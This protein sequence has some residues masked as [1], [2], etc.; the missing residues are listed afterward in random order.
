MADVRGTL[1]AK[2]RP[3]I[4]LA[5][6]QNANSLKS[7]KHLPLWVIKQLMKREALLDNLLN[8]LLKKLNKLVIKE[9]NQTKQLDE[10][11]MAQQFQNHQKQEEY[12]WALR[13]NDYLVAAIHNKFG[14]DWNLVIHLVNINNFQLGAENMEQDQE[15]GLSILPFARFSLN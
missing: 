12:N 8:M 13:G 15:V 5:N 6:I 14:A 2:S 9:Q 1:E 10:S 11:L 4:A 7:P 3:S